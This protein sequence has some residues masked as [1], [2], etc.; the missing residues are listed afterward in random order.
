MS[1][2]SFDPIYGLETELRPEGLPLS[3]DKSENGVLS[4]PDRPAAL[5]VN[6]ST[7]L[8]K[9]YFWMYHYLPGR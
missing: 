1:A 7:V 9:L 2:R 4:N 8:D 6:N 3:R 5:I